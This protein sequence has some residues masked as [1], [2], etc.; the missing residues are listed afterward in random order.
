MASDLPTLRLDADRIAQLLGSLFNNAVH[1]TPSGGT[2]TVRAGLTESTPRI[3]VD[4]AGP[5]SR[6]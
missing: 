3:R 6:K 1:C 5:A 4:D 2:M